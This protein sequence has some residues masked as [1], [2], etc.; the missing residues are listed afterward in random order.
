MRWFVRSCC[1]TMSPMRLVT[2]NTWSCAA[3]CREGPSATGVSSVRRWVSPHTAIT[4]NGS[5][6][7]WMRSSRR[8]A[9][10]SSWRRARTPWRW[11][12]VSRSCSRTLPEPTHPRASSPDEL[13][14]ESILYEKAPP[15]ATITLN[16]P[17]VLNA[18]DFRMLR[19]LARACADP[20][21]DDDIRVVVLT[22]AGRA[23]CVGADLK[24]WATDYVGNRNEY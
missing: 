19:E 1:T 15:R 17:E 9:V 22:G 13:G 16:R 2:S 3:R 12:A 4:P 23:F 7:T 8:R 11:A 21:W 24:S 20:S 14:F 6:P 18:F 5:G 10:T